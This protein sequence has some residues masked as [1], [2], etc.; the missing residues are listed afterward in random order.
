MKCVFKDCKS[1]KYLPD[2]SKWN[3]S[4]VIDIIGLFLQCKSLEKLPD[5]SIWNNYNITII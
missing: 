4:N 3:T 1:L 2:I 5:I